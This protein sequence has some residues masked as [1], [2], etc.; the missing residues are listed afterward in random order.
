MYAL[1]NDHEDKVI[2]VVIE[3]TMAKVHTTNLI[4]IQGDWNEIVG[5]SNYN[6]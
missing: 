3:V 2:K 4:I 1:T 6:W 5:D